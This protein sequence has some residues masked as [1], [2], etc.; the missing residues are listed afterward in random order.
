[1]V[2]GFSSKSEVAL[3]LSTDDGHLEFQHAGTSFMPRATPA[4]VGF[5]NRMGS[6]SPRVRKSLPP[7]R[8]RWSRSTPVCCAGRQ[9]QHHVTGTQRGQDRQGHLRGLPIFR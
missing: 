1:M 3:N 2:G 5:P 4:T 9:L 6:L 8:R 7:K